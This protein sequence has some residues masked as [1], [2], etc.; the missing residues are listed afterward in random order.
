MKIS[1][2]RSK[3]PSVINSQGK[4][5]VV[6]GDITAKNEPAPTELCSLEGEKMNCVEQAPELLKYYPGLF[7]VPDD[8]CHS[9]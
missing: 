9:L 6:G 7:H 4:F 8:F 3:S 2:T 1:K 5:L